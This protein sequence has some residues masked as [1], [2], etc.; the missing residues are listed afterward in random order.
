MKLGALPP[1]YNPLLSKEGIIEVVSFVLFSSGYIES[2]GYLKIPDIPFSFY[3]AN[4]WNS[5]NMV[6][7]PC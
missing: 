1:L 3:F 5:Y 4:L 2:G 6:N 7:K